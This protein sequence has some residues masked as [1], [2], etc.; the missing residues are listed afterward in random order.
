MVE[1]V[2]ILP[3]TISSFRLHYLY[4]R[5]ANDL[6]L[7]LL[8]TIALLLVTSKSD[9]SGECGGCAAPAPDLL[10]CAAYL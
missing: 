7:R 9:A 8:H 10:R 4:R 3:L 6:L 1:I 5:N 2:I